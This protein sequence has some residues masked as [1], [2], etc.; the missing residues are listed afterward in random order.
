MKHIS[1]ILPDVMDNIEVAVEVNRLTSR[2]IAK[3]FNYL[4]SKNIEFSEFEQAAIKTQFRQLQDDV[5]NYIGGVSH[6][7]KND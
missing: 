5:I 3:L 1:E 6:E 4:Q 7:N 2:H